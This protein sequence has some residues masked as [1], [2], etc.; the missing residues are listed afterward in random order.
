[1]SVNK[2]KNLSKNGFMPTLLYL[3]VAFLINFYTLKIP[4]NTRSI[5]NNSTQK[6]VITGFPYQY[7]EGEVLTDEMVKF[8]IRTI[9][10]S[11]V[12]LLTINSSVGPMVYPI[13]AQA[14]CA[15]EVTSIER[16][17]PNQSGSQ[18]DQQELLLDLRG[19]A[20]DEARLKMIVLLCKTDNV[21]PEKCL[22]A[23][24]WLCGS[25]NAVSDA[26]LKTLF[27]I[28]RGTL[29]SPGTALW[30]LG[31]ATAS[32]IIRLWGTLKEIH[33]PW[34]VD[35]RDFPAPVQFLLENSMI[36]REVFFGNN[37]L[38]KRV[39]TFDYLQR[40][41]SAKNDLFA[42]NDQPSGGFFRNVLEAFQFFRNNLGEKRSLNEFARSLHVNYTN[43]EKE[44]WVPGLP[45]QFDTYNYS[46]IEF[47]QLAIE[48]SQGVFTP[49]A[50]A[51]ARTIYQAKIEGIVINPRR[52][53]RERA[54][55]INTDFRIDGPPPCTEA[56]GKILVGRRVLID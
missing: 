26:C 28:E 16:L 39:P 6:K 43:Y 9:Y 18:I 33:R 37:G 48:P 22:E 42:N 36:T 12:M 3:I 51:E 21:V 13:V 23:V 41:L 56:D 38:L 52:P 53:D 24:Y 46:A 27:D 2:R 40:Q 19:G 31:W 49:Q 8:R 45:Q 34:G 25:D 14:I 10:I 20:D 50:I 30:R 35:F 4:E 1:M 15:L 55:R 54:L 29:A 44:R 11:S 47:A 17:I 7:F 32:G 5:P